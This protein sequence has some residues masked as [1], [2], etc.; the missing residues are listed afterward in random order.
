MA[1]ILSTENDC[2][3]DELEPFLVQAKQPWILS[4]V[5]LQLGRI[6]KVLEIL[7]E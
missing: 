7:V 2:L 1:S 5:L 4:R 3:L 6:D